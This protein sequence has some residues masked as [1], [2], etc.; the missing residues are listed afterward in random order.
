MIDAQRALWSEGEK[1]IEIDLGES[2]SDGD[3]I[4]SQVLG[5]DTDFGLGLSSAPGAYD[6]KAGDLD[7]S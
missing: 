3:E 1:Y 7:L 6:D 2:F 5:S 4:D